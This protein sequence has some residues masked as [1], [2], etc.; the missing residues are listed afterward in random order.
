MNA[1]KQISISAAVVSKSFGGIAVLD[2]VDLSVTEGTVFV[3][4]GPNGAGKTTMVR[5]LST[6]ISPDSGEVCVAGHDL[7]RE[8]ARR[9][10]GDRGYRSVLSA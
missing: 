7:R 3:P 2:R 5:I 10:I 1:T 6:P 9:A 4:L 8:P